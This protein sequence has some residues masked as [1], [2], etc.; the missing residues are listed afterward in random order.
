[1]KSRFKIPKY[2]H[3]PVL[4]S[5][6]FSS[7][8]MLGILLVYFDLQP[9]VPLFYSLPRPAQHLVAKKWLFLLPGIS[10][11]ISFVH[12]AIIQISLLANK[13]LLKI[14]VW[15]TTTIQFILALSLLRII[16]IIK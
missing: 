4:I 6:L 13:Q 1:M 9:E 2:L 3:T 14:F 15:T 11:V 10:F 12:L 7:S 5:F 8:M 16:T